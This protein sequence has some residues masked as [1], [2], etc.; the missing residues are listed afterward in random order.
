MYKSLFFTAVMLLAVALLHG[1]A[2]A[3]TRN[4]VAFAVKPC[5]DGKYWDE[6]QKKCVGTP[7]GSYEGN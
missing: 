2:N 7:R 1:S 3:E 6:K 4:P 5:P